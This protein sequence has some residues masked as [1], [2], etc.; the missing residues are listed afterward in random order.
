VHI[1][2]FPFTITGWENIKIEI[3]KGDK[4]FAEWQTLFM[5]NIRVRKV[6]YSP[7]YEANH[8]C[9]KGHIIYCLEGSMRT[10]LDD[11]RSMDMHQ[12]MTYMVGDSNGSHRSSTEIGCLLFIV[13]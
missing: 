2:S 1:E 3:H 4:G 9:G 7:G 6:R 10:L 11:G 12:G 5:N 8:W 13:D